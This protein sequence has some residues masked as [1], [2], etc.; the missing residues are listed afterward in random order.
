MGALTH[1]IWGLTRR[2]FL[3]GAFLASLGLSIALAAIVG[4]ARGIGTDGAFYALSGFHLFRGTGFTYSDVPNTFTWPMLSILVGLLSLG[5][6]DLQL[7]MHFVLTLSFAAGVLPFYGLM[8]NL[9][10]DRAAR[11]GVILYV[12]NGFLL[13]MSARMT[14][15]SLL[16]FFLILASYFVSRIWRNEKEGTTAS[17]GS[18]LGAGTAFGLAYLTKPEGALFFVAAASFLVVWLV[19]ARKLG[20]R[21]QHMA[22]LTGAFGITVLPQLIFIH[23]A[24]G[25]WQWTTYNR[26]LFRGVVEPLV[27]LSPGAP[28]RDPRVE[29]N[30]NAY[31]VRG[32]YSVEQWRR[33]LDVLPSHLQNY[34]SSL[35]G[36][37]GPAYVAV[38]LLS[39]V[40]QIS[41]RAEGGGLLLALLSPVPFYFFWYAPAERFFITLVPFLVALTVWA[42]WELMGRWGS[43][44][45]APTI[46][47]VG[48]M[49]V[50]VQSFMPIAHHSPTNAVI[51]NHE[52]M[53][54]WIRQHKPGVVGALL[55][56]RKP[57]VAFAARARYFRYH[58]VESY[59][60]LV[61][62]L[63]AN[64]V[65]YLVVDDFY[66]RTKN[67]AVVGL[68]D[69]K[70]TADLNPIHVV[71]DDRWGKA[72]L[73][74]VKEKEKDE[75]C[76]PI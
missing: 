6:E 11:V 34:G 22:A 13:R 74:E 58:D 42:G 21:M 63:K 69:G 54:R 43:R 68:L 19:R 10:D 33:D 15:E 18:F 60:E 45:R 32:P 41:R 1:W 72:I 29:R 7:C 56:D 27:S 70:G 66:T 39:I 8:S 26:F 2:D 44:R 23:Q 47:G 46:A 75:S 37:I 12:F 16:I 57:Y 40:C 14:A 55:A 62:T 24:T 5:F 25:K 61:R 67:P 51:G 73:Y 36:V 35:F 28:S 20:R 3:W 48:L 64:D 59:D 4:Y 71:E 17:L 49:L 31:I 65:K 53:G 9:I 30:Y 50:T 52:K 38:V 76:S